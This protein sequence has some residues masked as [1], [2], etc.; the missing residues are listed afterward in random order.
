VSD[1][2]IT[3]LLVLAV[4]VGIGGASFMVFRSPAFWGDVVKE[5]ATK[6]WPLILGVL[7]KPESDEVRKARQR[8]ERMGGKWDWHRKKCNR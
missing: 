4:L 2:A 7:T 3:T 6:A 5:L 8:C 1:G